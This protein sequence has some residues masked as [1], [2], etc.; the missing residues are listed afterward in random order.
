M[1]GGY[2]QETTMEFVTSVLIQAAAIL[3]SKALE[4][5]ARISVREGWDSVKAA[6]KRKFGTASVAATVLEEL[7]AAASVVAE[8]PAAARTAAISSLVNQLQSLRLD[9]DSDLKMLVQRLEAIL[10]SSVPQSLLQPAPVV[11]NNEGMQAEKVFQHS[12]F[13]GPVTFN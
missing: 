3:G 2:Q 9:E 6:I 10:Q 4:E 8:V 7:P 5:S 11:F 13:I 1:E 12:H